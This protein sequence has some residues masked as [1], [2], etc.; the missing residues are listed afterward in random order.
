MEILFATPLWQITKSPPSGAYNW[1][2]EYQKK[3]NSVVISNRKGYQSPSKKW[4]EFVYKDYIEKSLLE[5]NPEFNGF[6]I[7]NWWLNINEK[8]HYNVTHTHPGLDLA[9]IWYITDNDSELYFDDPLLTTISK[10]YEKILYPL[11]GETAS[12][13]ITCSAGDILVFPADVPH[14]VEEHIQDTKRISV[15]FNIRSKS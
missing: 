9:G 15:S 3:N 11:G 5:V 14:R 10:L 4:D 13:Y 7:I 2:L 1:A 6:E 8:G 12:K